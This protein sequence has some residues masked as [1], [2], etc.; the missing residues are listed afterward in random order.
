M[1][2]TRIQTSI[3]DLAG[4]SADMQRH[5]A[6]I[7]ASVLT[8][9]TSGDSQWPVAK[10][11]VTFERDRGGVLDLHEQLEIDSTWTIRPGIEQLAIEMPRLSA[12]KQSDGDLRGQDDCA[13]T[14]Q[15]TTTPQQGDCADASRSSSSS[16]AISPVASS[17][18]PAT[19]QDSLHGVTSPTWPRSAVVWRTPPWAAATG[20]PMPYRA[21]PGQLTVAE[22]AADAAQLQRREALQAA[23]KPP[24]LQPMEAQEKIQEALSEALQTADDAITEVFGV[25]SQSDR[26]KVLQAAGDAA[27]LQPMEALRGKPPQSDRRCGTASRVAAGVANRRDNPLEKSLDAVSPVTSPQQGPAKVGIFRNPQAGIFQGDPGYSDFKLSEPNSQTAEL[28]AEQPM[29][30]KFS[31]HAVHAVLSQPLPKSGRRPEMPLAAQL[32]TQFEELDAK[33]PV[34]FVLGPPASRPNTPASPNTFQRN[35]GAQTCLKA[36]GLGPTSSRPNTQPPASRPNTPEDRRR[37]PKP[38]IDGIIWHDRATPPACQQIPPWDSS[39]S[40]PGKL[41]IL[42]RRGHGSFA[43]L[44]A[45]ELAALQVRKAPSWPRSWANCSSA[46]YHCF[47]TGMHGPPCIVWASLTPDSLAANPRPAGVTP[48]HARKLRH[49]AAT[50]P[51]GAK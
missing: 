15:H 26:P 43:R 23:G 24:R 50:V 2:S 44:Q 25:V 47:P 5:S 35:L 17:V 21:S 18:R 41:R 1:D 28:R 32:D 34:K 45:E 49:A 40:A 39:N 31:L 46:F 38:K 22:T 37:P 10:T 6:A 3:I 33:F 16:D 48:Q 11:L 30:A 9:A 20:H 19:P 12:S 29:E 13:A 4:C 8:G 14:P 51:D 27:K 42:P 36:K 7:R